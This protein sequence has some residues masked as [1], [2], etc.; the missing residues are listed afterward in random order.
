MKLVMQVF[1]TNDALRPKGHYSQAIEHNGT[2]Y[3]SGILP[4]D[5]ET[6]EFVTGDVT[7]Q[8]KRVFRNLEL[9]LQACGISKEQVIKTTVYILDIKLW[10]EVD[11]LYSAFFGDHKPCR[12]IVPTNTLHYGSNIEMEVV[13]VR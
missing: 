4:F 3:C 1:Q 11:A 9:I 10:G 6:G 13:A 7:V 5:D 12:S 8:C 2:I